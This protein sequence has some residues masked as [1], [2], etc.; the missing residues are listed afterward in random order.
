MWHQPC[1]LEGRMIFIPLCIGHL[2]LLRFWYLSSK[3][4]LTMLLGLYVRLY[5]F[6]LLLTNTKVQSSLVVSHHCFASFWRQACIKILWELDIFLWLVCHFKG[7]CRSLKYPKVWETTIGG[8]NSGWTIPWNGMGT[9][10]NGDYFV[11]SSPSWSCQGPISFCIHLTSELFH[12]LSLH[13][14][15]QDLRV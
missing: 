6:C 8:L 3:R 13:Q 9:T 2:S 15:Q 14:L 7:E 12:Y 1:H 5:W 4:H 11:Y 10:L